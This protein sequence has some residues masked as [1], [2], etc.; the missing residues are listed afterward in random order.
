MKKNDSLPLF[1]QLEQKLE[2]NQTQATFSCAFVN[3]MAIW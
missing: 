1:M 3:R 2:E